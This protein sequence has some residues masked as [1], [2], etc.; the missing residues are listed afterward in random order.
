[1]RTCNVN[2]CEVHGTNVGTFSKKL[3]TTGGTF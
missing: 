2:R 3:G 1:M